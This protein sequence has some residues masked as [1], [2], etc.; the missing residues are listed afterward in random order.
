MTCMA[1]ANHRPLLLQ[2]RNQKR[3]QRDNAPMIYSFDR[4]S[5]IPGLEP[6]AAYAAPV[7]ARLSLT[8]HHSPPLIGNS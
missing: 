1:V 3:I 2:S 6:V 4:K 7:V 8:A 5:R